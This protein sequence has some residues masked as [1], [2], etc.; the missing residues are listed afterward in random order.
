[1]L[2]IIA[3]LG[4]IAVWVWWTYPR[5]GGLLFTIIAKVEAVR[6][7]LKEV[8]VAIKH[9]TLATYQ[10]GTAGHAPPL[11]LIH[12]FSADKGVWFGFARHFTA[13]YR[14]VIP[15]LA[16][17]GKNRF[18]QGADYSIAAQAGRLIELL[19]ACGIDTVHVVGSSMGAY[20]A[21]WLATHYPGRVVS[22]ALIGPVGVL[23]PQPN[24]VEELVNQG[25]NPFLIHS[26]A[27]FDRFFSMTM[28]SPPWIPQVLLAAEAQA[29][30][31]RRS[32]LAEIFADFSAS[33]RLEPWLKD[34]HVPTLLLWGREDRM[35]PIASATTWT[36][37]IAHAQL[38]CWDA[39][40]HL[41]MV[42]RPEQTAA[43]YRAFLASLG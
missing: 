26:R 25:D 39:V 23:L 6:A 40:G 19:D 27:Q 20:V 2:V 41:P 24:E 30:I 37:G 10:G 35:V 3:L 18:E 34:I 15:D 13:D 9:M 17:H 42:E 1:M 32:E 12:G 7:R 29:Y 14:V 16:G 43:R 28:A 11:L 4:V 38:E 8:P 5:V 36:G 31:D 33:P 22:L 21:T